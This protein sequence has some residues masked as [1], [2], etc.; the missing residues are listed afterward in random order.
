M[1]IFLKITS[2]SEGGA[3]AHEAEKNQRI[4]DEILAGLLDYHW[5]DGIA[6]RLRTRDNRYSHIAISIFLRLFTPESVEVNNHRS[7]ARYFARDDRLVIDQVLVT[8]DYAALTV[9][10][11]RRLMSLQVREQIEAMLQ[12]Y[13]TRYQDFDAEA[14][15]PMLRSRFDDIEAGLER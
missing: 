3:S 9:D 5:Q 4:L 14:F 8:A 13:R 7:S 15:I 11:T 2:Q 10:E 12:K 6:P 1:G